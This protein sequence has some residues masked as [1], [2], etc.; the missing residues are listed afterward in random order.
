M[1]PW[2]IGY[3]ES[4]GEQIYWET[5]GEGTPI[6]ICHGAGSA[7]LSFYQQVAGMASNNVQIVTWDQRGFGNST[8]QTDLF[9]I[10]ISATDLDEVLRETGLA[11]SAIHIVGQAMGGLVAARWAI[12]NP[13]RVLSLAIW[14]GPFAPSEDGANL[15]WKLEPGDKGVAS[16]KIDRQVGKI[17][18]VGAAFVERDRAGTFLYQSLQELGNRRPTYAQAFTAA[19]A[20]PTPIASIAA[21]KTPVLIGRGEFDHVADPAAYEALAALIPAAELVVLPGSG[22]SPYFETPEIWN[23]A[24]LRHVQRARTG[25]RA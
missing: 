13:E 15:I 18:S 17:R 10:A 23:A 11:D 19:Q 8:F 7:H 2:R 6:V 12:N 9:G 16:T 5:S 14:D 3:A 22:H 25:P 21:L 4:G 1:V 24:T 20:E